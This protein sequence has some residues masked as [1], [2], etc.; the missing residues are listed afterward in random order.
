MNVYPLEIEQAIVAHPG[1]LEAAVF[2]LPD[3]RWGQAVVAA[4]VGDVDL[5]ELRTH[6]AARLAPYKLPKRIE[7]VAELPHSPTGKLKR[8]TVAAELGLA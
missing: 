1:V 2:P 4:V 6:L 3:E 5:D 7:R 8:S